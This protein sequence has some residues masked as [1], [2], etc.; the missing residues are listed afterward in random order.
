MDLATPHCSK[1]SKISLKEVQGDKYHLKMAYRLK[2][3]VLYSTP[4][5]YFE[6]NANANESVA[7]ESSITTRLPS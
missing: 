3:R 4:H 2:L 6:E 5:F 1:I 7:D